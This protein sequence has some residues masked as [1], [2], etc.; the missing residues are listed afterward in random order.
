[1]PPL[2]LGVSALYHDSAAALVH[3][4]DIIAA[5]EEERFSRRKH[6]NRLPASAIEYCLSQATAGERLAAVVYYEDPIRTFDRV[7][8]NALVVGEGGAKQWKAAAEQ[9]IGRKLTFARQLRGLVGAEP[10]LLCVDHH[11]SHAASAF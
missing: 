7:I 2:V 8:R 5:A 10:T 1:M 11:A 9:M 4:G 3:G 6:D